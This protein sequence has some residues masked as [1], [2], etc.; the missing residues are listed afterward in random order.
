MRACFC[1]SRE[2]GGNC[3]G[4]EKTRISSNSHILYGRAA[5]GRR[6]KSGGRY[7]SWVRF[8]GR[9]DR[10]GDSPAFFLRGQ[11]LRSNPSEIPGPERCNPGP[12][13]PDVLL[14][15]R[16]IARGGG[17]FSDCNSARQSAVGSL[18]L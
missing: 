7:I 5:G 11:L 15:S 1:S 13:P 12:D 8:R 9:V 17:C 6:S 2:V 16:A 4:T 10:G 18:A 14:V 3:L